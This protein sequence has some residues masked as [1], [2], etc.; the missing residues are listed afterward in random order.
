MLLSDASVVPSYC[1][2]SWYFVKALSSRVYQVQTELGQ[3]EVSGA[4]SS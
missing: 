4:G 3:S 1:I 2:E